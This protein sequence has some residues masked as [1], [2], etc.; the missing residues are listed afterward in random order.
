MADRLTVNSRGD[1]AALE[2]RQTRY[3]AWDAQTPGL[4]VRVQPSGSRTWF[5]EY[6]DPSGARQ[7]V[8]IGSADR[9]SPADARKAARQFGLDPAADK[10]KAKADRAAKQAEKDAAALRTVGA[11]LQNEYQPN[12][13]D[14]TRSGDATADRVRKAWASLLDKDMAQI[15]VL[16]LE[17][18]R[19]GRL[20]E[21]IKPQTLNRDWSALRAMLH[22]ARRA[23]LISDV[24][25][26]RKLKEN[27]AERIRWLGQRDPGERDRFL[28]ALEDTP[29]PARTVVVIAYWTGMR[30]GE[31]FSLEWADIDFARGQ[32]TVR[33]E[34]AKTGSARHIPLHPTLAEH[35]TGLYRISDLVCPSPQTSERMTTIKTAWRSLTTRANLNDFRLHDVRHD[36]ASRIVQNGTDLYVVKDLLGHSSITLTERYA[37]LAPE[38]HKQALEGLG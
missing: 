9:I 32:I 14:A 11:Y 10:R 23:G 6:R 17:R 35:L 20:Q 22:S 30:R 15:T 25:E 8:K 18:V 28:A 7:A 19:R 36:F 24:P 26:L 34:T 38:R 29:E 31:V 37:H 3:R 27:D 33:P 12:H 2:P 5:Y 4:C 13:L 1:I 16:D 21:G